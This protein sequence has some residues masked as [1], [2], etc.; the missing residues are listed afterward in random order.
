[1]LQIETGQPTNADQQALPRR[2]LL[3]GA[4]TTGLAALIP[5]PGAAASRVTVA[6]RG[7]LREYW[8]QADAFQHNLVPT[9]RDGMMGL[10]FTPQ[11]TSFWALGFRAYSPG[12]QTLLPGSD[13]IGPNMGIPGPILRAN[14]GDVVRVHFRNNDTHY[15]VPH[16]MHTHGFLYQPASDGAWIAMEPDKPGTAVGLGESYIYDWPAAPSSVGTWPYHDH[17]RPFA[18]GA[19]ISNMELGAE[20]GLFGLSVITDQNTPAVDREFFLFMYDLYQADIPSLAQDF[21][22]FNGAC[23]LGNTPVFQARRGD[24]VRWHIGALG[25]EFHAFHIHGHRWYREG[26]YEDTLLLGP[27]SAFELD[28]VEDNPGTWLYHCHVT[29]HMMGGMV[30]QYIVLA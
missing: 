11:Q 21:D 2:D 7:K 3:V 27:S 9:G 14:V 8:I 26:R 24:R 28:Y 6:S 29:D 16:S 22:S 25:K 20:L 19:V 30:G 4:A 15:R 13:D 18:I 12:W 1:M 10:R 23:Y 17:S 5:A